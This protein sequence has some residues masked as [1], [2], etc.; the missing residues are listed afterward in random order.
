MPLLPDAPLLMP[1]AATLRHAAASRFAMPAEFDAV[2]AADVYC[3][4]R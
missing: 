2:T 1:A 4:Q 3:C